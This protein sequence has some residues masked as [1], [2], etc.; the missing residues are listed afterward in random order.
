MSSMG[1]AYNGYGMY[2]GM[3][4]Y[5]SLMNGYGNAYSNPMMYNS[6]GMNSMYGLGGMGGLG[7]LS[8]L[9]GTSSLGYDVTGMYNNGMYGNAYN[10]Y[11]TM[12]NA[13]G[14]NSG[15]N[16][17]TGMNSMTG[18]TGLNGMLN[19]FGN[20]VSNTNGYGNSVTATSGNGLNNGNTMRAY[21]RRTSQS[22][23]QANRF[24]PS[25]QGCTGV[26][27]GGWAAQKS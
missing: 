24:G 7:G 13:Y 15:M 25:H 12:M 6:L 18:M 27:C 26:G 8:S 19:Q 2:G 3:T 9:S 20:T 1:L 16:G 23:Q 5:S 17:M 22:Y 21:G 10:P 14:M 4:D 11:G